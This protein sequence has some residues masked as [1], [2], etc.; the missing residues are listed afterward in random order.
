MLKTA[1][2]G[3]VFVGCL[4]VFVN[5]AP[6]QQV[7]HALTGTV[8]SIDNLSKTLTVFQDNGSQGDFKDQTNDK[9]HFAF[10]KKIAL[11]ATPA[12]DFKKKGAY[13]IVFY[14]GDT[15]DRTAVALKNLGAGPFTS[16]EGAL[17]KFDVKGHSISLKDS[18]GAVQTFKV[19]DQTIAEGYMGV[20]EGGKFQAQKGD[21]VRVVASTESGTPTALF[22]REK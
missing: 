6:A 17:V 12:D 16:A 21:Q 5:A 1:L 3:C 15:Q 7:V 14:Y 2:R 18:S 22:M 4:G 8:S 20:V 9:A 11:E 13:V 19:T 10:D